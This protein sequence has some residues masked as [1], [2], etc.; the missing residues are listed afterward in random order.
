MKWVFVGDT[1]TA[2]IS[3]GISSAAICPLRVIVLQKKPSSL[4]RNGFFVT[5]DAFVGDNRENKRCRQ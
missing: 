2:P 4:N 5:D 1:K 3:D